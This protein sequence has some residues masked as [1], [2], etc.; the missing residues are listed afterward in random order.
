[1]ARLQHILHQR[2][3]RPQPSCATGRRKQLGARLASACH[4]CLSILCTRSSANLASG[5]C[6]QAMFPSADADVASSWHA[7]DCW[8][9]DGATGRR[10][11][12]LN[13]DRNPIHVSATL[14]HLFGF[15]SCVAHGMLL[16]ARSLIA[17][18]NAGALYV[19]AS[20][21]APTGPA[22]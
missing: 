21:L 9:L 4:A 16:L 2:G 15:R 10:F 3:T 1:M 17:I 18:Q 20:V 5:V 14:A 7:I 12:A 13:G 8:A 19:W 6:M 22:R 11:A